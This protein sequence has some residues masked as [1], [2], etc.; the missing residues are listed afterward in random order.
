MFIFLCFCE[1]LMKYRVSWARKIYQ[2]NFGW[3]SRI[4]FLRNENIILTRIA[5]EAR[6]TSR[7]KLSCTNIINIV[8]QTSVQ[9]AVLNIFLKQV[10]SNNTK[11]GS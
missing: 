3:S 11:H 8:L 5:P 4:Q 2:V 9:T 6:V 7:Q 10:I 1:L